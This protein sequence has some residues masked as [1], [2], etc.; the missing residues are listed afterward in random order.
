VFFYYPV[1]GFP[2]VSARL[3]YLSGGWRELSRRVEA[4]RNQ[5]AERTGERPIVV[6]MD[7]YNIAS[8]LAFYE[9]SSRGGSETLGRQLFIRGESL[10]YDY[11]YPTAAFEGKTL[12][13]IAPRAEY[14]DDPRVEAHAER[15]GPVQELKIEEHGTTPVLYYAQVVHGY[16]GAGR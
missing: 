13:L 7:R 14:F 1:H 12:L 4:L 6:G 9:P 8:E 10:M 2:G 11:W 16:R 15:L 5:V 3:H